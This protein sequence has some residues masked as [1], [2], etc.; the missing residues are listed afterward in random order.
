MEELHDY[1][2]FYY[3]CDCDYEY[4]IHK[5]TEHFLLELERSK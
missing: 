2:E 1:K 4:F 5:A 3:E